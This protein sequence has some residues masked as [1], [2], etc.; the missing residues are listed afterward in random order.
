MGQIS[1]VG[2]VHQAFLQIKI[3]ENHRQFLRFIWLDNTLSNNLSYVLLRFARV[4][5]GLT[6]S[7][8]LL[9]FESSPRK[10]YTYRRLL[11]FIQQLLLKFLNLHL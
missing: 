5:F 9:N 6:Y 11:K 1:I 10:V 2:D 8:F 7:L 3:N 4:V